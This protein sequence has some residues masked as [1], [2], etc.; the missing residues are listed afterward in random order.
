M[1]LVIGM[2]KCIYESVCIRVF[3]Y[4]ITC[5]VYLY[6]CIVELYVCCVCCVCVFFVFVYVNICI[7]ICVNYAEPNTHI[8]C[9]CVE[10]NT[11][12]TG[13]YICIC[14]SVF[15]LVCLLI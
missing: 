2:C 12:I 5:D 11:L 8:T 3:V 4:M 9:M 6:R 14:E 13:M 1:Y 7:C 15:G 10:P